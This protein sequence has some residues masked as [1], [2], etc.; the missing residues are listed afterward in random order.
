MN[1]FSEREI[2]KFTRREYLRRLALL[3]PEGSLMGEKMV[4]SNE[5]LEH[6]SDTMLELGV[7]MLKCLNQFKETDLVCE[8]KEGVRNIWVLGKFMGI[9]VDVIQNS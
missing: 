9:A 8:M 2:K 1:H 4:I 7:E 3:L 5:T 6:A